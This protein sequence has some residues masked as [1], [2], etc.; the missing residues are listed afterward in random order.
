M[1]RRSFVY[2]GTLYL[3]EIGDIPLALL[4]LAAKYSEAEGYEEL[5]L[6]RSIRSSTTTPPPDRGGFLPPYG[7]AVPLR[8]APCTFG[9]NR[10]APRIVS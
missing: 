4:V 8:T 6:R 9:G 3:D 2:G 10:R 1:K 7:V 5:T